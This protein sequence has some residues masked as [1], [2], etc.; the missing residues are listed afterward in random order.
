MTEAADFTKFAAEHKSGDVLS[1]RV[2]QVVPF[3]AFI[4]MTGGVH[5]LLYGEKPAEDTDVQVKIMEID[6]DRQRVSLQFA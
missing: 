5:G 6:A 1:G 4:E 3:G 2:V